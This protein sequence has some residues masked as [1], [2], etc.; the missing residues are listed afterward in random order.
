MDTSAGRFVAWFSERGLATLQFP[1]HERGETTGDRAE[2]T[3]A[4]ALRVREALESVFDASRSRTE[5]STPPLDLSEGTPFQR[6]VWQA[7]TRIERGSVKSYGEIAVELGRP[8]AARAVGAACGANPVPV[9][10][11]CH[12]VLAADKTLGGFSGGLDWKRRLLSAEGVAW[13]E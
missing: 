13:R 12:R 5:Q 11:P 6:E 4:W 10:I 2:E 9:L 8:G 7:L 1:G 3:G